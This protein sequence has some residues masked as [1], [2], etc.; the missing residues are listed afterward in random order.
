MGAESGLKSLQQELISL[1]PSGTPDIALN[2]Q[3]RV[4]KGSFPQLV[5][6]AL[7]LPVFTCSSGFHRLEG[8]QLAKVPR[9]GFVSGADSP[10]YIAR[11]APIRILRKESEDFQ[12]EG[13]DTEKVHHIGRPWGSGLGGLDIAGHPFI[14]SH[15]HAKAS[16]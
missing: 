11:S 5:D 14:L 10:T 4:I 7:P 3:D 1:Q 15:R 8:L 6:Q 16:Y 9:D 12:P 2:T 13:I